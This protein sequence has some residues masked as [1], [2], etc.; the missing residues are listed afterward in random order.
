MSPKAQN[1]VVLLWLKLNDRASD[2][3][4]KISSLEPFEPFESTEHEGMKD[5]HWS[6]AELR[7][8][9][10]FVSSLK[11]LSE[12]PEIVTLRLTNYDDLRITLK[13]TN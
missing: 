3:M 2:L 6:F 1:F 11:Q 9:E 4:E 8:A 13:E 10:N 12:A 5:F 7:E